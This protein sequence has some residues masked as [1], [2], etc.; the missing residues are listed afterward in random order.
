MLL[1]SIERPLLWVGRLAHAH[2]IWKHAP[3]ALREERDKVAVQIAPGRVPMHNH[4]RLTTYFIYKG[5][6]VRLP[7]GV[8]GQVCNLLCIAFLSY[9]REVKMYP[10]YS[11]IR[12]GSN[13]VKIG[14]LF[15]CLAGEGYGFSLQ[16]PT[17]GNYFLAGSS[18]VEGPTCLG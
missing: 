11:F 2:L 17:R 18:Q 7:A 15:E 16:Y 6:G 1:K 9:V 12:I 14:Y 3:A 5:I 13:P 4:H 10:E 8:A